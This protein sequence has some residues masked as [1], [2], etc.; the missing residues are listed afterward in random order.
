LRSCRDFWKSSISPRKAC[1]TSGCGCRTST[2]VRGGGGT[3]HASPRGLPA[4]RTRGLC[5][6][7][8]LPWASVSRGASDGPD[9]GVQS[10]RWFK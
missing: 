1:T 6:G 9:Q 4:R 10:L 7:G 8:V 2:E 5:A 3:A